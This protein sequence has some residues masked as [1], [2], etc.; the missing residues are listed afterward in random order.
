MARDPFTAYES[1][2]A[3]LLEQMGAD[4]PR[5]TE[6][7]TF[8]S[9]LRENIAQARRYGDTETRRAERAQILEALNALA[10]A[11]LDVPFNTLYR[12]ESGEGGVAADSGTVS[13]G[14]RGVAIGGD[15]TGG[16]IITG[17]HNVVNV[18]GRPRSTPEP[19]GRGTGAGDRAGVE[20]ALRM[21]RRT[22]AILEEQAAAYTALTI[23][24]H[25]QI[26]LEE[27]RAKVAELEAR[28]AQ[29]AAAD[30][31]LERATGSGPLR[32][33]GEGEHRPRIFLCHANEDKAQVQELYHR[34][35]AAGYHPWLDKYDL[36]PGQDW[37]REIEKIIR[38]P[39]NLIV[40]CLSR[41]S[42]T[43]RAMVQRE[44]KWALDVLDQMPEDTI[45]LIPARLEACQVPDRLSHLH[46]VNLFEQDGFEKLKQALDFEIDRGFA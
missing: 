10:L 4:H 38:D 39:Y 26:E 22:L 7:L 45:Y 32:E 18:A 35:K 9:R 15:V 33:Q 8:E 2:L 44:I 46:Y 11:A 24:A 29:P 43:K 42:I 19:A 21:A 17:D 41:N 3:R 1:G 6:G 28:L 37:R 13:A 20:G 16:T 34:L 40:V 36:L 30:E 14:E 25:L 12:E 31:R 27:Q 23:P 5:Y